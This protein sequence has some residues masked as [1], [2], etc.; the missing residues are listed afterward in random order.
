MSYRTVT[1]KNQLLRLHSDVLCGE[2]RD[3]PQRMLC[4]CN[5]LFFPVSSSFEWCYIRELFEDVRMNIRVSS[6]TQQ[7]HI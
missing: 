2:Q 3:Q 4:H 5:S 6:T 7:I 1:A